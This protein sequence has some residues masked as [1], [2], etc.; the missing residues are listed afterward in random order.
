[1]HN[2]IL[3]CLLVVCSFSACAETHVVSDSIAEQTLSPIDSL[4]I[5]KKAYKETAKA[6][7]KRQK[8]LRRDKQATQEQ[9]EQLKTDYIALQQWYLEIVA[10]ENEYKLQNK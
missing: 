5:E 7:K 3:V 8:A 4:K 6:L 1:M 9:Y 10:K 2:V